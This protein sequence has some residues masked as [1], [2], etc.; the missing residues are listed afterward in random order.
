MTAAV[1]D[2]PKPAMTQG[3]MLAEIF[4]LLTES[5][6]CPQTTPREWIPLLLYLHH[7]GWLYATAGPDGHVDAA[8]CA[9]RIPEVAKRY[10]DKLPRQERGGVL[11]V[12]FYATRQRQQMTALR[13][14]RAY[15][16]HHGQS[17][18]EVAFHR[19]RGGERLCRVNVK[20]GRTHGQE[21]GT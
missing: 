13:L 14:L 7:K 1:A 2:T 6:V 15:L 18:R 12:P 5:G 10:T 17:V 4:I 21:Q 20:G 8:A 16:R 19:R 11:Y 3:Q 9:Y